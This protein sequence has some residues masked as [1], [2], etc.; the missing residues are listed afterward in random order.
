M[1]ALILTRPCEPAPCCEHCAGQAD[2]A[3]TGDLAIQA[4][5]RSW[6]GYARLRASISPAIPRP[7]KP[8]LAGSG[9]SL[10]CPMLYPSAAI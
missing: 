9:T 5:L 3:L 8:T 4:A 6:L 2:Y 7:I 1:M 10:N